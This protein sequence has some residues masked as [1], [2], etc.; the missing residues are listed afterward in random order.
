[1]S[2]ERP[3]VIRAIIIPIAITPQPRP[4]QVIPRVR[5]PE[6]LAARPTI[7]INGTRGG[8]RYYECRRCKA[9]GRSATFKVRLADPL[10]PPSGP[11]TQ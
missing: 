3:K 11:R 7:H 9:E 10:A 8:L 6:C 1:M 2:T 5:C 4:T